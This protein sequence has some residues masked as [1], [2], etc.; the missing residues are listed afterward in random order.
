MA[1]TFP[2]QFLFSYE[3]QHYTLGFL[4]L[5]QKL[6]P[7]HTLVETCGANYMHDN[8]NHE[9]FQSRE[10][11]RHV[12]HAIPCIVYHHQPLTTLVTFFIPKQMLVRTCGV[13]KMHDNHNQRS[14][15]KKEQQQCG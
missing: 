9:G 15:Q 11:Q 5:N 13:N 10:E 4:F 8:H 6:H 12:Y 2:I 14:V 7:K 3:G 1:T